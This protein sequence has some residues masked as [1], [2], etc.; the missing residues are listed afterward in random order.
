MSRSHHPLSPPRPL[1]Y[2][3][4]CTGTTE[5]EAAWLF[6]TQSGLPPLCSEAISILDSGLPVGELR[7]DPRDTNAAAAAACVAELEQHV[8]PGMVMTPRLHAHLMAP[9]RVMG[10]VFTCVASYG[11]SHEVMRFKRKQEDKRLSSDQQSHMIQLFDR[12]Q[13]C[14]NVIRGARRTMRDQKERYLAPEERQVIA[15]LG[16]ATRG[17][18]S[19][20]EGYVSWCLPKGWSHR[21]LEEGLHRAAHAQLVNQAARQGATPAGEGQHRTEAAAAHAPLVAQAVHRGGIPGWGNQQRAEAT[22]D[23]A[24]KNEQRKQKTRDLHRGQQQRRRR[25]REAA[26]KLRGVC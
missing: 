9:V 7:P 19:L 13:Q 14:F 6:P 2:S 25:Q 11:L 3:P 10:G 24:E 23:K 17:L 16:R 4:A 22:A 15:S 26:E 12:T 5:L 18:H 21:A 20:L 8:Q 1:A